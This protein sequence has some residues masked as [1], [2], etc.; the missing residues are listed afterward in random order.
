MASFPKT[1]GDDLYKN[2]KPY[3][4]DCIILDEQ[5]E[6]VHYKALMDGA[7]AFDLYKC[8]KKGTLFGFN[9]HF[10]RHR[11]IKDENK[12]ILLKLTEDHLSILDSA[13]IFDEY[14]NH[15]EELEALVD[16]I[17]LK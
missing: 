7:I 16:E 10:F 13:D 4:L 2:S 1:L 12:P 9:Y 11:D 5:V 15:V 6:L 3:C 17:N 8:P 14:G